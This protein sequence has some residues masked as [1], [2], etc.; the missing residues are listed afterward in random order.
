MCD[1][2]SVCVCVC[3]C[4]CVWRLKRILNYAARLVMKRSKRDPVTP[5]LKELRWL[6]VQFRSLCKLA[7][8]AYRHFDGP[9]PQ[10]L[11]AGLC[12][13]EPSRTLRSSLE[14]LLKI[15]KCN[16][17]AL[18]KHSFSFLA[19]EWRTPRANCLELPAVRYP[20]CAISRSFQERGENIS[21]AEHCHNIFVFSVGLLSCVC[22]S[23]S[24][25]FF[26]LHGSY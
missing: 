21:F 14:K 17:R 18:G 1:R 24:F 11:S 7:T 6:P 13:Y 5:L 3:V 4:V 15:P 10:Y 12:T 9:L 22:F 26:L 2:V 19:K 25:L 16:T 8:L 23:F 20:K